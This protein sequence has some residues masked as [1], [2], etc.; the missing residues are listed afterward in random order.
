[1]KMTS[2]LSQLNLMPALAW[3]IESN[4]AFALDKYRL[5]VNWTGKL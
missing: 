5:A 4:G 3:P 1:M 2:N